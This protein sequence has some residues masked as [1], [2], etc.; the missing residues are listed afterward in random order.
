MN[1][2]VARLLSVCNTLSACNNHCNQAQTKARELHIRS[3]QR[4][5]SIVEGMFD[6]LAVND[7]FVIVL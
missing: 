6:I 5:L 3:L 4:P 2:P 1:S 7:E